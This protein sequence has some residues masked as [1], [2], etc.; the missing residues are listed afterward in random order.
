MMQLWLGRR[1]QNGGARAVTPLKSV[2]QILDGLDVIKPW[3]PSL[4]GDGL[5]LA[6]K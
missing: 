5:L 2:E 1:H 3:S 6:V 4:C